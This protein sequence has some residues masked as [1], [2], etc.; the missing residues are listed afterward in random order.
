MET[1]QKEKEPVVRENLAHRYLK[2]RAAYPT[3][4]MNQQKIALAVQCD[5]S[6]VSLAFRN[7]A[8]VPVPAKKIEKYFDHFESQ[9]QSKQQAENLH[10]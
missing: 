4:K 3:V 2:I 6:T 1:S 9:M 7:P 8:R 5:Q 10:A